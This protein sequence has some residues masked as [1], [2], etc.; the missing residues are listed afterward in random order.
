MELPVP[1]VH[2][3]HPPRAARQE[4]VGESAGRRAHVEAHAT[5]DGHAERLEGSRQLLATPPDEGRRRHPNDRDVG[6]DQA[7]RLRARSARQPHL[8]GE[9]QPLRLGPAARHPARHEQLVQAHAAPASGPGGAH[10]KK[11]RAAA[12]RTS[13]SVSASDAST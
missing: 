1:D 13:A 7:A 11:C 4:T 10:A 5:L 2:G 6:R 8:P 12:S 3:V 9:N